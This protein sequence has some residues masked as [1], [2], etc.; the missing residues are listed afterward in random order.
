[1]GNCDI[2]T[3]RGGRLLGVKATCPVTLGLAGVR[4]EEE[5]WRTGDGNG[6]LSSPGVNRSYHMQSSR[7]ARGL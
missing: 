4:A 6:M 7:T 5:G 2:L 3:V 1:M